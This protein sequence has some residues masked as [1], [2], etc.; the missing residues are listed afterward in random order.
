MINWPSLLGLD[1]AHTA[2]HL[3]VAIGILIGVLIGYHLTERK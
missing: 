3:A 1:H 2:A